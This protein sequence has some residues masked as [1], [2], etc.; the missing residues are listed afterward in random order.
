MEELEEEI[1]ETREPRRLGPF[2]VRRWLVI[3][4]SVVVVIFVLREISDPYKGREYLEV[5]HGNH[6]HYLPKDRNPDVPVSN[7]PT[8]RP[9][10]NER[11]L[12]NGQVV[13]R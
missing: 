1:L 3:F 10:P 11:I 12:P 2:T 8:T 6:V 7:F 4:I 13:P 5:S 9:A